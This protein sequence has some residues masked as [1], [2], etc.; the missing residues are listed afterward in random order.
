MVT[1]VSGDRQYLRA[2]P[3]ARSVWITPTPGTATSAPFVAAKLPSPGTVCSAC[4]VGRCGRRLGA[5][6]GNP[7]LV[8]VSPIGYRRV[9]CWWLGAGPDTHEPIHSARRWARPRRQGARLHRERLL[10]TRFAR[11]LRDLQFG[12]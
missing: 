6:N 10:A 4:G 12:Y 9:L 5:S 7:E 1:S 2:R 3:L 8:Y 11:R